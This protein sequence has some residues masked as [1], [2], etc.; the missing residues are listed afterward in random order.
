MS[1]LASWPWH[2]LRY[3]PAI[4]DGE[5]PPASRRRRLL[6]ALLLLAFVLLPLYLWP[7]R[8]D[9]GWWPASPSTS[10]PVPDPRSAAALAGIPRA[11]WDALMG[12][13][14]AAAPAL[15]PR[16]PRNLTMIAEMTDALTGPLD[17]DPGAAAPTASPTI[18]ELV[19]AQLGVTPEAA[20]GSGDGSGEA[21]AGTPTTGGYPNLLPWSVGGP[22]GGPGG[23]ARILPP[24]SGFGPGDPG[25]PAP[26]PEPATLI[27]VGSNLALL[28]AAAWRRHRRRRQSAPRG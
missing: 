15:P 19:V 25:A 17:P 7:L 16:G 3:F 26:T 27:L 13:T 11:I 28:G 10:G 12:R 9:L 2:G 18:D 24:S 1:F 22:G 4:M 23:G 14:A 8:A 6:I 20:T 21:G 5:A